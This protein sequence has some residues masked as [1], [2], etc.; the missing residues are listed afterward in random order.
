MYTFFP[1]EQYI[2]HHYVELFYPPVPGFMVLLMGILLGLLVVL[3]FI[4]PTKI[5]NFIVPL[6]EA[7][8]FMYAFH[9]VII[10][11]VFLPLGKISYNTRY[12]MYYLALMGTMLGIG[13]ILRKIRKIPAY[14]KL[15]HPVRWIFG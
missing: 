3:D 12:L 15:P 11:Y 1:G 4:G 13:L 8:L 9:L 2:R 5:W 6:G 14:K 10:Q 7:S